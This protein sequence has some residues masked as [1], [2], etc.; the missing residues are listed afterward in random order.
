MMQVV[1]NFFL[2]H[3]SILWQD[4]LELQTVTYSGTHQARNPD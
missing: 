4:S 3:T 1:M 2:I